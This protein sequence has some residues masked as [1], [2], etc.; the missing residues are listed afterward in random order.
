MLVARHGVRGVDSLRELVEALRGEAPW[1]DAP[2]ERAPRRLRL[3]PDLADVRGHH[4]A[5][6][7]LEVS[8]AGGHHVV[9]VGPPG[10]GKTM[11]NN[12][13]AVSMEQAVE[14]E[15]RCQNVNFRTADTAEAMAAFVQKRKPRFTG[16]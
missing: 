5:R 16:S 6:L 2:P 10:S 13:F 3:H 14:D 1:P 8:A 15:A 9:L 7:A 4:L 12:S 11:L